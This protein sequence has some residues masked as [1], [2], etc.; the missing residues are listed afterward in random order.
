M[1]A[2]ELGVASIRFERQETSNAPMDNHN[3]F[4]F[5]LLGTIHYG[6]P[7]MGTRGQGGEFTADDITYSVDSFGHVSMTIFNRTSEMLFGSFDIGSSIS[8]LPVSAVPEPSGWMVMLL[9][10]GLIAMRLSP[11]SPARRAP[12]ASPARGHRRSPR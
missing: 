3:L 11:F 12:P 2:N 10:L 5:D 7:R 4:D 8:S 6:D 9:G 1:W